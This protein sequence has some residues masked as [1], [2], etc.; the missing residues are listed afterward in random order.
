MR[1][2][3]GVAIVSGG[4]SGI[5]RAITLALAGAG[6]RVVA[7]GPRGTRWAAPPPGA[8]PPPGP[9]STPPG[10]TPPCSTLT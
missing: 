10:S 9:S 7:F 2:D 5:G 4:T 8:W 6:W 3:D 1:Q